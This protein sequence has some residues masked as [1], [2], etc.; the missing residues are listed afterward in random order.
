MFSLFSEVVSFTTSVA[1]IVVAPIEVVA[2][3]ANA[4]V[5]PISEEVTNL[6]KDVKDSV[7]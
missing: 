7:S 5:K 4:A 1:K 3:V 6:V 2:T